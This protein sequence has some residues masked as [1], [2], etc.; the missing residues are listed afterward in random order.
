M[1]HRTK[2]E[3]AQMILEDEAIIEQFVHAQDMDDYANIVENILGKYEM[4][5]ILRGK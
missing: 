4:L 3:Y 1:S 2:A 5:K